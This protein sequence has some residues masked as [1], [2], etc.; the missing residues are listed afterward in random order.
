METQ[1]NTVKLTHETCQ[2]LKFPLKGL[3]AQSRISPVVGLLPSA[4][5]PPCLELRTK[6]V[7]DNK[8][9]EQVN[10]FNYDLNMISYEK[11][12]DVDNKLHNYLKITGILNKV[13][14]P[15]KNP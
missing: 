7:I 5:G 1:F 14:R 2:W 9:I 12:L 4:S 13:S 3:W 10:S 11:E 6:I 15:Q 8:I